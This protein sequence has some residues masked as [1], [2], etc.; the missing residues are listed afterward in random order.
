MSPTAG[1]WAP[2]ALRML[3]MHLVSNTR[4]ATKMLRSK[5]A[6]VTRPLNAELQPI[7]V[8]TGNARQPVHP[9]AW[10]RQQKRSGGAKWYSSSNF[11]ATVRRFISTGGH[12]GSKPGFRLDRSKLPTSTISRA[13]NQFTGRAP[14]A[15]TLRPNLTGGTLGRTAGGYGI[16]GAGR[17]GGARHFSHTP[18]APAQVIQNVSQAMR[19][20]WLSGHR[21]Q[22]SG[23][24]PNGEKQYRAISATQSDARMTMAK[25]MMV[26]R[27]MPGAFIDFK[28][29]P[30]VTALSSL[31]VMMPFMSVEEQVAAGATLNAEGFLDVLS[32][33]FARALKDLAAI[34]TDLKS[35]AGLGDL[36]IFLEKS[37]VLRVRFPGMDA[38]SVERLCDDVGVK[39]GVV[40]QDP[41]FDTNPAVDVAL[42]FP[43]APDAKGEDTITSPGGSLRSHR[44]GTSSLSSGVEDAFIVEEF[45]ENPWRVSSGSELEGYES[46]SPPILSSSG[47]HCSEEFEGLEGVYRFLEECDNARGRFQ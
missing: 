35:L 43:F 18:A 10:L 17:I 33:D 30:T 37:N 5:L 7:A 27:P 22:F 39:R 16:P 36:P 47:E 25:A 4:M 8:R 13:V 34:M 44:S 2:A 6:A 12:S 21:A 24:G 40:G 41:G 32:V 19:A 15:S 28:I 20:F 31:G 14:F 11:N 29:S 1:M 26:H 45:E 42:R 3:R 23:M 46:M 38:E 9:A